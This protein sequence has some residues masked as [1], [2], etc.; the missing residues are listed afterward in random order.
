M[1]IDEQI[2]HEMDVA[3]N[4]WLLDYGTIKHGQIKP[5]P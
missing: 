1:R 2:F 5:K 4:S 3:S